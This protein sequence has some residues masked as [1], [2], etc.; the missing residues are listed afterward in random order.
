LTPQEISNL[1]RELRTADLVLAV[2]EER[3]DD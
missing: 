2:G 1:A 3:H